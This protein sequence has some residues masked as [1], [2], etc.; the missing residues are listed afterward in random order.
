[1]TYISLSTIYL[2]GC[3]EK[4]KTNIKMK[5][6]KLCGFKKRQILI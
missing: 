3:T 4:G 1:M 2:N 6:G 5:F